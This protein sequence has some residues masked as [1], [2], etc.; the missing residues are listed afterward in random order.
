MNTMIVDYTR[1]AKEFSAKQN[2]KYRHEIIRLRRII[3]AM[4]I[5]GIIILGTVIPV[6]VAITKASMRE[7]VI[8][9]YESEIV[10]SGDS[11]WGIAQKYCPDEVDMRNFISEIE[12]TNEI[13][14]HEI[15]V[16][17]VIDYPIYE[18]VLKK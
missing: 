16:G 13:K 8:T 18:W 9:G 10:E 17:Q 2:S 11:L 6:T 15:R 7:F 14:N 5:A 3:V 4:I 12:H 1:Q